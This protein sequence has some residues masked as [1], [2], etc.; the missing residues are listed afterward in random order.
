[1]FSPTSGVTR[2]TLLDYLAEHYNQ[3]RRDDGLSPFN[4]PQPLM[5][6]Q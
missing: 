5:P 2:A 3:K 4:Q 6:A 1:M